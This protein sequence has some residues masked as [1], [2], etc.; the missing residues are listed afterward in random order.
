MGLSHVSV[1]SVRDTYLVLI[2]L[3]SYFNKDILLF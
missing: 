2:L 1:D 3:K